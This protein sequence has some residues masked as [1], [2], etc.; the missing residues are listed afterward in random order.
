MKITV[1]MSSF[2]GERY[3]REQIDSIL[4][5]KGDFDLHLLVRDDGSTD[6]TRAILDDY[7][8][9]GSLSW[10]SGENLKP[11]RSFMDLVYNSPSS[12][13][14][15]FSDQDD[16]W[17]KH[18]LHRAISMLRGY[19]CAAM[20]C[21]NAQV[22]NQDLVYCGRNVYKTQP[23]TDFYTI[24]CGGGLLGCTMVFNDVIASDIKRY[25]QPRDVVMHDRYVSMLAL[26]LG[27]VIIYDKDAVFLKYRQHGSN[28]IG[29]KFNSPVHRIIDIAT[30]KLEISIADQAK[31]ILLF[32]DW[33]EQTG[34]Y[35]S[36]LRKV[37]D[38]RKTL[39]SRCSL[40]FSCKTHYL[41]A[42]NNFGN[43]LAILLGNK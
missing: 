7:Q 30:K 13:F 32:R 27:G 36:W 10:Y 26:L 15:A 18:K 35:L 9:R 21:S 24:T 11:A 3:I 43:R 42:V 8:K 6:S 19:T 1:L 12:D 5:Q 34:D 23:A 29:V 2:N 16:L 25:E 33:L 37:K 22:V 4:N 39:I 17:D 38:Y 14:Y 40:A 20:Y 41:G 31:E 28:A